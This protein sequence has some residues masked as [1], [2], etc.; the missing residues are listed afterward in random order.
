MCTGREGKGRFGLKG[1]GTVLVMAVAVSIL[2]IFPGMPPARADTGGSSEERVWGQEMQGRSG[3][4]EERA[5]VSADTGQ[6]AFRL[7]GRRLPGEKNTS[8]DSP[9]AVMIPGCILLLLALVLAK[10][11]KDR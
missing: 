7:Y 9:E 4:T 10:D 5:E 8:P 6:D 3:L 11:R 1:G 2:L